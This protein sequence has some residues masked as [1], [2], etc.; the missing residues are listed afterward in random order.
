MAE[1]KN[2]LLG[3]GERLTERLAAPKRPFKK[4]D[5]YSFSEAK[6]FLGSRIASANEDIEHL[7]A[8]ACPN[9]EAMAVVTLHPSYLAK[10]FFPLNLFRAIGVEAVGSRARSI[11]PRKGARKAKKAGQFPSSATAEIFV[12]GK[13]AI[14]QR[15]AASVPTWN[16]RSTGAEELIRIEDV[17]C[18]NPESKLQPI[19]SDVDEPMLELVLHAPDEYVLEGFREYMDSLDLPVDPDR[20]V[21]VSGLCFVGMRVPRERHLD[22]AKFSFLRVARQMPRLRELAPA[23]LLRSTRSTSRP[24][25]LPDTEAVNQELQVAIFDGGVTD[26]CGL[27]KWVTRRKA[28]GIGHAHP[29]GQS[30]GTAVTS[31]VLFGPTE[32]GSVVSKPYC[33]V[34]HFRVIDSDT[35]DPEG[36]YYEVL[37][38]ITAILS[39]RKFDFV[40]LSLGPEVAFD[41]NDVHLWTVKLDQ[42]FSD[43]RTFVTVAAGNTGGE[44]YDSGVA[45][46]QSPSDCVNVLAVGASDT[47][48]KK[49]KR[50]GYSSLGPGRSPGIVKPDVIAFGGSDKEPFWVVDAHRDER[51]RP[52]AGTS[53]AAPL[54]LRTAIGL[55]TYLG[56][57][58]EPIALKALLIHHSENGS[59]DQKEV[60][61]G[62]IP[63]E[64]EDLV[65]CGPGTAHILYQGELEPGKYI[66]ARIPMPSGPLKGK[67]KISATFCYACETD[68]EDIVN[69][70]RAGL[71]VK[72]RPDKDRFS[73]RP[74]GTPTEHP[75]SKPFFQLKMY[76]PEEELRRDAHQWETTLKRTRSFQAKSLNDP[77]FD[78]HY[79]ARKGGHMY[80]GAKPIPYALVVT[81]EAKNMPELYDKIAQ[82]YRTQLQPLQPVLEIP[83]RVRS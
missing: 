79:N 70:T 24:V 5:L 74:D 55:R 73:K 19:P 25:K 21:I 2:Y 29:D 61:W 37:E 47:S 63:T 57:V 49:W 44:D 28:S 46:I 27:D 33:R 7:P 82:R 69:Y 77:V 39:Q 1:Q 53:F 20:F 41:D 14:F 71:D 67:V 36:N 26:T 38:R 58:V 72:F 51:V 6:R 23:S 17:Y 12:A 8:E 64:V 62:R 32:P 54:A 76:T 13:R 10:S 16:E 15:W 65:V 3:Y 83:V 45:R 81:V 80:T 48:S 40:N 68:P 9:D 75:E 4:R 42:L 18:P 34:E 30:H 52:D 35:E 59:H 60:G 66:R 56:P 22:V 11:V 31:S 43:G 50:A 78:I